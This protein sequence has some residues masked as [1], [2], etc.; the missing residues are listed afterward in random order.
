MRCP[1]KEGK[2]M[3][4]TKDMTAYPLNT[5]EAVSSLPAMPK[6]NLIIKMALRLLA[7]YDSLAGP[8]R[9]ERERSQRKIAAAQRECRM[10]YDF[11]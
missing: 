1:Y 8:P 11:F 10:F 9:T 7:L 5:T 2:E 4:E 6:D 3:I